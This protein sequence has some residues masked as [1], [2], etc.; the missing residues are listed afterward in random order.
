MADFES[1]G[2]SSQGTKLFVQAGVAA[3]LTI[4]AITKAPQASVT[5]AN[6]LDPGDIVVFGD[7][8]GM[9]EIKDMQGIVVTATPTDFVV[10]IDSSGFATAGTTG[11]ADALD[12]LPVCEARNFNGFDGQASEID[13][14]TLCST[15]KEFVPGLQDFGSFNFDMN[16]VPSDPAQ[17]AMQAAKAGGDTLWWELVLPDNMGSWIFQ[18]FVR[19][20][21]ISGGVDAVLSSS[22]VLRITGEPTFAGGAAP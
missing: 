16:Y 14:T 3:A 8:V 11:T 20:M 21:T 1:Q 6:T 22:V 19:Q 13:K 4:S 18:A 12:L 17:M 7:V 5:A 10:N 9:P 2:V 15:A